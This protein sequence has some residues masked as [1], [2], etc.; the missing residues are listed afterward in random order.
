MRKQL[1]VKLLGYFLA[2]T[3]LVS[4]G[5]HFLHAHQVRRN[6]SSLLSQASRAEE[7]GQLDQAAEYL[8]RYLT[9]FVRG[10]TDA[11]ATS[12]WH[13]R[14]LGARCPE[15]EAL[16]AR[17]TY[18]LYILTADEVPFVQDG[19]RD[20]EHLRGWMTERF[21]QTLERRPDPWI[22]VHGDRAR[23][24]TAATAR[25]DQLLTAPIGPI[26]VRERL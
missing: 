19:T 16:A 10:D 4:V 23:R 26:E 13:E 3:A 9:G 1:N 25:I 17:R 24:L 20:G 2:T 22:E 11:L 12:I 14:Y 18:A 7:Q 8:D 15:V 6:A 5:V 21:R